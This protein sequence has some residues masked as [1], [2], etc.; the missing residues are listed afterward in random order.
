MTR[1]KVDMKVLMQRDA[2]KVG[3]LLHSRQG[4]TRVMAALWDAQAGWSPV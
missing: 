3:L 1:A 4:S 2:I